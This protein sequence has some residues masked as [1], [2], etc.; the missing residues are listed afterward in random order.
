MA[1]Y[2]SQHA[3]FLS[4]NLIPFMYT[5]KINKKLTSCPESASEHYRPSDRRLPTFADRGCRVVSAT[6]PYGHILN[7]LDREQVTYMWLKKTE[8]FSPELSYVQF[9]WL[10]SLFWL[11]ENVPEYRRFHRYWRRRSEQKR[12]AI[13]LDRRSAWI[14][15][16]K[17]LQTTCAR[18]RRFRFQLEEA[19]S[20]K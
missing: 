18:D 20:E 7:F 15:S 1:K 4:K 6:D 3:Y 19:H 8:L 17:I 9:N 13:R 2:F 10:C 14:F 16:S 11:S 5:K 12:R